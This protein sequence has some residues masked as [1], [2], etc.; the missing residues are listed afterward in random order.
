MRAPAWYAHG[1]NTATSLRLILT[2]IP[3]LPRWVVPPIGVVTTLLCLARMRRERQAVRRN[4]ARVLG[5]RGLRL[6][7]AV[8]RQF[9]SFSRFMVS[10]CDLRNLTAA[11]LRARLAADPG[12]EARL[13]RALQG[14]RGLV[15]LTAHLGNWEAG[16][17]FLAEYGVPVNVVMHADRTS[18]AERWLMRRRE[19]SSVRVLRVGADPTA[20]LAVHA[21]LARNEIV[22]MQGDRPFG[23]RS[24]ATDLFGF[25]FRF[26][27][28]PF[29]VAA[30]CEAPLIP[31]F[32]L[33]VGWWRWRTEIGSPI[34]V[35]RTGV[36]EADPSSAVAQ[37]AAQL[38]QVVRRH[39]DQWFN[40]YDAWGAAGGAR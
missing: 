3:R 7:A 12:G 4:Q 11:Q 30:A 40:F 8:W 20:M 28:G 25:P 33:Q 15:V 29:L 9:Y 35:P 24:L 2:I 23:G 39:P 1:L 26:P 14:G 13:R 32:V 27:L 10:F 18:A 16:L 34:T 19:G 5:V 17:R 6:G 21:A 31:S 38:Q 37:Y 36:R 22:A